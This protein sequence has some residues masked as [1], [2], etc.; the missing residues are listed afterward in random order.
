M[1]L[2]HFNLTD[3]PFAITPDPRFLYLSARHREALAHLLYGLGEGG[4]FVQL[5][6]EVG[7]GKT[8]IC[9]CLLEHVPD[10]VDLALVLNPKVTAY[11]L[12]ATVCDE[13]GIAY[14]P[15][16][17]SIK[18]LTDLLNRYLL[19][20]YA[21]GR[22][23]VLIIDEAQNLSADV[24]EQVRLLTNLET[25][26]QKLLQIILIGQPELRTLLARD[27]M[28]QLAQRV[29]AR[30]HLE[31]ISL[32]ET[33]AYIRHRLQICGN[34]Q[35]LFNRRAVDRIQR[36]S[37]GIPRLINVL[38]DR[39]M[40]GA[41]VE[42]KAQV[43]AR[44][45]R[46]AARE[47]LAEE[48]SGSQARRWLPA[49]GIGAGLLALIMLVIYQPWKR[50]EP[51]SAGSIPTGDAPAAAPAAPAAALPDIP[52]GPS[53]ESP[54]VADSGTT[55]TPAA[56][57]AST[58]AE[59]RSL[60]ELLQAADSSNY[61]A[62]W[63]E[64]LALWSVILPQSVKP[65][66]CDY[67]RQYGLLCMPGQGNWN[68]LR[69]FDRP[70]ILS[71]IDAEGRR[72][73]V[74]LQHLDDSVAELMIGTDLYRLSVEQV[75]RYWYGEYLL[76]FQVPPGGSMYLKAGDRGADVDWLRRQLELALDIDI[77]AADP[78]YFD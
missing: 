25:A 7:T 41:Y 78:Q 56:A 4:G 50:H 62:A 46:K 33:G 53:Q 24:L 55:A 49:A 45:V 23:T 36:L 40:L 73:P 59:T 11:E 70:A 76:L 69:Q 61:R 75:D 12:I 38:C 20:A 74:V 67:A 15:E 58:E 27:D 48:Q 17:A 18:T 71:L 19:D 44:V 28:R 13:L 6:G 30:Y 9:R 63:T 8:T 52:D 72:V 10:N 5:T 16:N 3:R 57:E 2:K 64:L 65:D 34:S 54:V 60:G 26:T 31:P 51:A 29:T 42:G 32:E 21:Q 1:Y 47:V 43:D 35:P 77:P 37:G 22:R 68:I 14:P 39:A 66:F